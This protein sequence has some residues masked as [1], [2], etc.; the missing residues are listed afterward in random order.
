[1]LFLGACGAAAKPTATP[2]VEDYKPLEG[3]DCRIRA[4]EIRW[5]A[6]GFMEGDNIEL[7]CEGKPVDLVD[8]KLTN[9][10]LTT[11]EFGKI[12]I[13]RAGGFGMTILVT[14][15]QNKKLEEVFKD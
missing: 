7:T 9:G 15:E 11:K 3:I 14:S 12:R 8:G 13:K 2:T 10:W 6:Q 4:Q 1:M 5:D